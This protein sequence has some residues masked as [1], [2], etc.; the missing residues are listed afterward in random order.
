M[1]IRKK[2]SIVYALT[3]CMIILIAVSLLPITS[4]FTESQEGK[5]GPNE[6]KNDN[7]SSWQ[8]FDV[9][10]MNETEME[11]DHF[12]IKY[13][14]GGL[15]IAKEIARIAERTY[16]IVTDF[17]NY[18]PASKTTITL[19]INFLFG[20]GFSGFAEGDEISLFISP[21]WDKELM[22]FGAPELLVAH[23]ILHVVHLQA[24]KH[25]IPNLWTPP[26]WIVEGLATYFSYYQYNYTHERAPYTIKKAVEDGTFLYLHEMSVFP[27]SP[28]LPY[29]EGYTVFKYIY[30]TYGPNGFRDF[31][32][33]IKDWTPI[34]DP[35]ENLNN[36]L[37][38]CFSTDHYDFERS[39]KAWL[40]DDFTTGVS[41]ENETIDGKKLTN[42]PGWFFVPTSWHG[43]NLLYIS[44][45]TWNSNIFSINANGFNVK[46]LTKSDSLL[47]SKDADARYS[48]DGSRIV[49]TSFQDG[50]YNLYLMESDG[51]NIE[52]LTDDQ[53]M[54]MN[55]TW[56]PSGNEIAFVSDRLGSFDIFSINITT[57]I[58][59][60]L[61]TSEYSDG[62]PAFSPGGTKMAFS[63][64]RNG[65]YDIFVLD[66]K[67][68]E[69]EQL[70]NLVKHELF[71]E[72]S[73]K[74]DRIAFSYGI[75]GIP[76][77]FVMD[78]DG[79][80]IAPL[81]RNVPSKHESFHP[82]W[83]PD[84]NRIAIGVTN[85]YSDDAQYPGWSENNIYIIDVE[86]ELPI[87]LILLLPMV[88]IAVWAIMIDL[89]N[90]RKR[91]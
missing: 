26:K 85:Y 87:I 3:S 24:S 48:P 36:V 35:L 49:L 30:E 12:V 5:I 33:T 31:I 62:S 58:I 69:V 76:H 29:T 37:Q 16:L 63:S 34:L 53:Y 47:G 55:P 68:G 88:F 45:Y 28:L 44:N 6:F 42:I 56:N 86:N 9:I 89:R 11:T 51:S 50:Y 83:S 52:E 40:I 81:L 57:K 75:G 7:T 8:E 66:F 80:N 54:N 67:T 21:I 2:D 13:E 22:L 61:V 1:R 72:W 4:N 77:V 18:T 39:W 25:Y 70:T 14:A 38:S 73:P 71:P 84:G 32:E 74:G 20:M 10:Q 23:E 41:F 82:I 43:Q 17:I 60:P 90:S 59:R 79:S 78:T 64:D 91:S 15:A 46:R 27:E 65:D 19:D